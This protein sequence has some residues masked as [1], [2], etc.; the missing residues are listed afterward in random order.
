MD[1]LGS[2]RTEE[3]VELS[4]RCQRQLLGYIFTLVRNMDDAE[5]LLQETNLILWRKFDEYQA[6]TDFTRWACHVA[7][8]QVLGFVRRKR[9]TPP[10]FDEGLLLRLA[11]KRLDRRKAYERYRDGLQLCMDRLTASDRTLLELCYGG[12]MS[13]K[14]I[15]ARLDRSAD[16]V[17][18][19]L[20]RI[21]YTLL[22]CI[23]HAVAR[24]EDAS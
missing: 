2:N 22:S 8:L 5:D 18:H 24:E 6:G 13:I 23:N 21:R 16:G 1:N 14:E 4:S 7:Y 11:D 20:Q 19:S 17:Y 12:E 9:R 15:A 10:N 3:F